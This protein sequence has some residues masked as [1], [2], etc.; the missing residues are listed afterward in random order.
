MF[1]SDIGQDKNKNQLCLGK[2]TLPNIF[3]GISSKYLMLLFI[4]ISQN[5]ASGNLQT[6]QF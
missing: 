6:T 3:S 1:E 5:K 4:R 2:A